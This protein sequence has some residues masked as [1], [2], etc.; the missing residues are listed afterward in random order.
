[1]KKV[2]PSGELFYHSL[3]KVFLTVGIAIA[4]LIS[5]IQLAHARYDYA[6]GPFI[7]PIPTPG[8]ESAS[9]ILF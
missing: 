4:L 6:R 3:K 2:E 9:G 1:M 5:G 8:P 7:E